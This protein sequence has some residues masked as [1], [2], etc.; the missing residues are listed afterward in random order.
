MEA[1]NLWEEFDVNYNTGNSGASAA[2]T[3]VQEFGDL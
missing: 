1:Q 2:D 3:S